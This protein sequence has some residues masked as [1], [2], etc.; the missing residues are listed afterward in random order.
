V[1]ADFHEGSSEDFL[2][3]HER[4]SA[5][6]AR[7]SGRQRIEFARCLLNRAADPRNISC[8]I[9][10]LASGGGGAPG[11]DGLT[12]DELDGAERWG[13]ARALGGLVRSGRYRP[14][15]HR[16]VR[17]PKGS[18]RGTRTL[19]I[20][21]VADRVVERAIVQ[22]VQPFLDPLFAPNSFGYRP[23]LGR[24]HALAHAEA[25]AEPD[26]LWTWVLD[27]VKDA[28]D[29]VPRGRLLDVVCNRLGAEDIVELVRVVVDS[30]ATKGIP[31][32]SSLSPLLLNLY[33]DHV[34]DRPW[35]KQEPATPLIRVADDLLVLARDGDA[36][37]STHEELKARLRA[38]GMGLKATPG[39]AVRDLLHGEAGDWLG[40]RLRKGPGGLEALPTDRCWERLEEALMLAHTKPAA[41]V[42]AHESIV[43]WAEQLGPCRPHLDPDDLYAR[44]GAVARQ[45]AFDEVPSRRTVEDALLSGHWRWAAL[46]GRTRQIVH[47]AH[48]TAAPPARV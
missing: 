4:E 40:F 47:T 27:D 22:V 9:D 28:F 32:G 23:G 39:S 19:R 25:I 34:L 41:P 29:N 17:I 21:N 35:A 1:P 46:R 10:Y 30:E 5:D 20:R 7:Q 26:G 11:P 15:P 44:I 45:Y 33:L 36:A 12:L 31:Q 14:G 37:Q 6:A 16:E 48:D 18:G 3:R 42:R 13:L 2:R 43:G 8:A 24:Q 38:A